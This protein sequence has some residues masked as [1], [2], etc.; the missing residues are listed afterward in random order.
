MSRF[1]PGNGYYSPAQEPAA[2]GN[3]GLLCPSFRSFLS[4]RSFRRSRRLPPRPNA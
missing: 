2:R 1:Q 3:L 4:L